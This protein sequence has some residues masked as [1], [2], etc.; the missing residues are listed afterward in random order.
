[1]RFQSAA[2]VGAALIGAELHGFGKEYLTN[3]PLAVGKVDVASA[4]R[5]A[6]EILDPKAYVIVM[7]GDAKDLEPQLKKAGWRYE[8]V[9]FT[10]PITPEIKAP[11]APVDTEGGRRPRAR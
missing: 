9:A 1:M 11:E 6:A 10:D 3:Y 2:D 4:K 5:A 8:K 7:V